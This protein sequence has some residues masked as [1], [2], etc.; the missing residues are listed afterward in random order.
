MQFTTTDVIRVR[1]KCDWYEHSEK[2]TK[3]ILNLE[4]QQR[5][6]STIKK[7]IVALILECTREFYESVF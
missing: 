3:L 2:S 7:L 1:N 4:K 6:K 5:A